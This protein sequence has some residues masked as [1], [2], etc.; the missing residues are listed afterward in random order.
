MRNASRVTT[1][2]QIS[3][4]CALFVA[5]HDASQVFAPNTD[6]FAALE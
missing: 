1:A 4:R 3:R 5:K 2:V 6:L